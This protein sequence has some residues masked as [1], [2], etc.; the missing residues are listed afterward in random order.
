MPDLI[1]AWLS[2]LIGKEPTVKIMFTL[3]IFLLL[4][5]FVPLDLFPNHPMP[6]F[7]FYPGMFAIGFL[8]SHFGMIFV[9]NSV[10]KYAHK[11]E[12]RL[13]AKSD[14]GYRIALD[15]LFGSLTGSEKDHLAMAVD[16]GE[17]SIHIR[18]D[19]EI[20]KSLID[21]GFI[22]NYQHLKNGMIRLYIRDDLT[23]ECFV[24]LAGHFN[25]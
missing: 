16:S 10:D 24:R 3:V 6:A 22:G 12:K 25:R 19:N 20:V 2:N 18:N 15:E 5:T 11:K 13:K 4:I 9:K 23:H 21:K 14:K 8:T 1:P 7:G 17:Y